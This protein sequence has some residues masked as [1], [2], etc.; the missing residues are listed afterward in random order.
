MS[1]NEEAI[2]RTG[3]VIGYTTLDS[4]VHRFIGSVSIYRAC[5]GLERK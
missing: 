4:V 2:S 1:E 5:M 3:N